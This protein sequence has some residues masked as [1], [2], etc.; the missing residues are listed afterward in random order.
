MVKKKSHKKEGLSTKSLVIIL[1]AVF[2][3]VFAFTLVVYFQY[4]IVQTAIFEMD[5]KI[6]DG[7]GMG[8]NLDDDMIHFGSLPQ[9]GASGLRDVVLSNN[10]DFPV[11]VKMRYYGNISD[12]I[13]TIPAQIFIEPGK[14][15][16]ITFIAVPLKEVGHYH[17]HAKMQFWRR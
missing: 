2:F 1:I 11:E 14:N 10:N 12:M 13:G 17:G 15:I 8:V 5:M 4:H 7:E 9:G 16:T 3:L 6:N